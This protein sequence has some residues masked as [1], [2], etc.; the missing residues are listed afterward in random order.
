MNYALFEVLR[1]YNFPLISNMAHMQNIPINAGIYVNACFE[2]KTYEHD[3]NYQN[4]RIENLK[5]NNFDPSDYVKNIIE[6]HENK[7][8]NPFVYQDKSIEYSI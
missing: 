8:S 6:T 2:G 3:F 1:F 4:Q 7:N 5:T